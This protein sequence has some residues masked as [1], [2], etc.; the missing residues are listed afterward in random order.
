ML[1]LLKNSPAKIS[2]LITFYIKVNPL[3]NKKI[4]KLD[5]L[6]SVKLKLNKVIIDERN[7]T[8]E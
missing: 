2:Y 6:I 5:K 3:N 1:L 4:N 8:Q 7:A